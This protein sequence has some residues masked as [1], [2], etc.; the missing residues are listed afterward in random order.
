MSWIHRKQQP[1]DTHFQFVRDMLI[2][3]ILNEKTNDKESALDLVS[4]KMGLKDRDETWS[5][6]IKPCFKTLNSTG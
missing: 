1:A 5:K 2:M 6:L 4:E 3:Q